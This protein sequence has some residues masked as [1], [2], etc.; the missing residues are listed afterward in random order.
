MKPKG[1]KTEQ[2]QVGGRRCSRETAGR[3]T[4]SAVSP[5]VVP[6]ARAMGSRRQ[7]RGCHVTAGSGDEVLLRRETGR[8]DSSR[9]F[10]AQLDLTQRVGYCRVHRLIAFCHIT[11]HATTSQI[12]AD[13]PGVPEIRPVLSEAR[14]RRIVLDCGY[15]YGFPTLIHNVLLWD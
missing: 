4:N 2:Q 6:G 15:F 10:S 5:A 11:S 12:R 8:K 3:G 13:C 1:G 14:R 9:H 7:A